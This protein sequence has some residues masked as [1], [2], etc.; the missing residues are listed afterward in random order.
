MDAVERESRLVVAEPEWRLGANQM[1]LV[2]AAGQRLRQLGGDDAAAA[3]RRIT[4]H[5]DMHAHLFKQMCA[6]ERLVYDDAL[7]KSHARQR[8]ELRIAAFDELAEARGIET[9]L[10]RLRGPANWLV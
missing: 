5:P 2:A 7:G 3:H 6:N 8:T 4:D 1:H 10:G 9:G